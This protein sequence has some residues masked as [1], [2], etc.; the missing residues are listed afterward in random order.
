LGFPLGFS[1]THGA[2][3]GGHF[4]SISLKTVFGQE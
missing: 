1:Q 4:Q 2:L 3:L